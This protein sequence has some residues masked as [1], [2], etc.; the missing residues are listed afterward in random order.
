MVS[1]APPGV[2][3]LGAG[4]WLV[5]RIDTIPRRSALS[6]D[7]LGSPED[8]AGLAAWEEANR[9]MLAAREEERR[10]VAAWIEANRGGLP[11]DYDELGRLPSAYRRAAI[12]V[13]A[14]EHASALVQEHPRRSVAARPEMTAAQRE[15]IAEAQQ[16]FTPAWCAGSQEL[17]ASLWQ[18]PFSQHMGEAFSVAERVRIFGSIGPE[19]EGIRRRIAEATASSPQEASGIG[20]EESEAC[21]HEGQSREA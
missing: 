7:A 12:L 11:T 13:L 21:S 1:R 9:A 14:P 4:R 8:T 17:H 19:D 16:I 20:Y 15:V 6:A 10:T 2:R 18:G 5:E 3:R